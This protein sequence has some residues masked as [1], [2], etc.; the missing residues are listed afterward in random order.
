MADIIL[1]KP[2]QGQREVV[3][4]ATDSRIVLNFPADQATMEKSGQNLVFR[5]EDGGSVE[6]ENFYQQVSGDSIPEFQVDG[7]LVA[8]ADF[9]NAFGPDIAPAAGVGAGAQAGGRYRDYANMNLAEGVDHLRELDWGMQTGVEYNDTI[10]AAGAPDLPTGIRLN[11]VNSWVGGSNTG[12]EDKDGNSLASVND[13]V[14]TLNE[15]GLTGGTHEIDGKVSASSMLHVTTENSNFTGM[16][17]NGKYYSLNELSKGVE[18]G[19]DLD[20]D[21]VPDVTIKFEYAG[22]SNIKVSV[23]LDHNIRHLDD[24][25]N[26]LDE[27][28]GG[29]G[30]VAHDDKGN[31]ASG[32]LGVVVV[33]DNP[34]AYDDYQRMQVE[35]AD[36]HNVPTEITGN[37]VTGEGNQG[38][39]GTGKDV[40]GA[41]GLADHPV[42]WRPGQAST[43]NHDANP[44]AD[45]NFKTEFRLEGDGPT[46]TVMDG[47]K[48]VGELTL[49]DDGSYVFKVNPGYE[50]EHGDHT[51][52]IPYTVTDADGDSADASLHITIDNVNDR[53]VI[54]TPDGQYAG[55]GD[56]KETG[57]WGKDGGD[58]DG[59]LHDGTRGRDDENASTVDGGVDPGQH[60]PGAS[61]QLTATD[62]DGDRL[63]FGP[64]QPNAGQNVTGNADGSHTIHDQYGD[65]TIW[66]DG[67]WEFKLNE[68]AANHLGEGDKITVEFPV[69]VT[70]NSGAANN[71]GAGNIAINVHGSNDAPSIT[72]LPSLSI[73][74]GV[75]TTVNTSVSGKAEAT[76]PD[77]GAQLTFGLESPDGKVVNALYVVPDGSGGYMLSE[78][79]PADGN[80]YGRFTIGPDGNYTFTVNNGASCVQGMQ[81]DEHFDFNVS[82]V[83]QDEHGAYDK[84]NVGVTIN[85]HNDSPSITGGNKGAVKEDG[86]WGEKGGERDGY[87]HDGAHGRDD[88]NAAVKD[89][90][91]GKGEHQNEFEGKLTASDPDDDAS[92]LTFGP[93]DPNAS[94]VTD[95]GDGSYTIHGKYGDLTIN[96]DGSYKYTLDE[97]KAQELAE[98][99]KVTEDFPVT[100]KDPHGAAGDGKI[101]I[102]VHGTNDAPV[103]TEG[104][105]TFTL[106]E[107]G[108]DYVLNGKVAA[109]D[110]DAKE[111]GNLHFGFEAPDGSVQSVLYAVPD[112]QGGIT[113]VT[114]PPAD[115]NYYGRFTM[116]PDGSYKF[117]MNNNAQCVQELG[118]GESARISV[119]V[120]VRDPHGAYDKEDLN[121]TI[122]GSN[123]KAS[124]DVDALNP[125]QTVIEAGVKPG[126]NIDYAGKPTASG[127]IHATDPD[128]NDEIH[129]KVQDSDG[130]WIELGDTSDPHYTTDTDGNGTPGWVFDTEHGT[131]VITDNGDGSYH[132]E[133]TL[134]NDDPA[135]N[136]L[137]RQET[138]Q[139]GFP[140][141]VENQ[142][143]DS[144]DANVKITIVGTNDRPEIVDNVITVDKNAAD[145]ALDGS[146]AGRVSVSDVDHGHHGNT[147]EALADGSYNL[148][149]TGAGGKNFVDVYD[150]NGNIVGYAEINPDGSY[151]IT[152]NDLGRSLLQ[153]KAEGEHLEVHTPIRVTD[154]DGAYSETDVTWRLEG[155]DDAPRF[156]N[157]GIGMK[158]DGWNSGRP[159]IVGPDGKLA[160]N[161]AYSKD[162]HSDSISGKLGASVVDKTDQGAG[163]FTYGLDA[164]R[165]GTPDMN[166][167]VDT[168]GDGVNDAQH[169]YVLPDGSLSFGKPG[170]DYIGE[171]TLKPDGSWQF[172]LNQD[173][174]TVNKLRPGESLNVNIPV[175]V[176]DGREDPGNP[177]HGYTTGGSI[178][179]NVNG[180]NDR[181][182]IEK[183]PDLALNQNPNDPHAMDS[184]VV[185]GRAEAS[186]PDNVVY[187][188]DGSANLGGGTSSA[189]ASE[190]TFCFIDPVTGQPTQTLQLE[191][192]S[193]SIDAK[194]G[195][196]TYTY[197]VF[198]DSNY[199]PP[200]GNGTASYPAEDH[201]TIYARDKDGAYSN[202]QDVDVKIDSHDKWGQG[203]GPGGGQ[204]PNL[205]A[206]QNDSS[207][208]EDNHDHG[209]KGDA[210]VSVGG[211]VSGD[212][213]YFFVDGNGKHVQSVPAY[214]TNGNR[215]GSYVIDPVTGEYRFILDNGSDRIQELNE[216]E[217][218]TLAPP[219]VGSFNGG[220]V[221]LPPLNVVGTEDK[222]EFVNDHLWHSI[223]EDAAQNG[224]Y[225][226]SGKLEAHD[227]DKGD[228]AILQYAPGALRP[229]QTVDDNG[230]GT[231][232][233][234]GKYG[235]LV[236]NDKTGGY[237][238]TVR[239]GVNVPHG[240][241]G[242]DFDVKVTDDFGLSDNATIHIDVNGLNT[243]PEYKGPAPDTIDLKEDTG[244]GN[245][246]YITGGGQINLSDFVDADGDT[247]RLSV[248]PDKDG[249]GHADRGGQA[250]A[251]GEYGTLFIKSDGSYEYRLNNNMGAVQGLKDG[252]FLE[253]HFVVIADDGY[254]G[255]VEIPINVKV[256]GTNDN[257]VLSLNDLTG[258]QYGAGVSLNMVE[259]QVSVGGKAVATDVDKSDTDFE[260]S[261]KDGA[262]GAD[263]MWHLDA[264]ADIDAD[265]D[266]Q[267]DHI[268]VGEFVLDPATGEYKFIPNDN[269][270]HLKGGEQI[271]VKAEVVVESSDGHGHSGGTDS[272]TVTVNITGT[273]DAPIMQ[274][275]VIE[276]TEDSGNYVASGNLASIT[277]DPDAAPGEQG[278][279]FTVQAGNGVVQTGPN[280]WEGKYGTLTLNTDGTYTY[281]MHNDKAQS[282]AEGE[283]AQDEFTVI[284]KDQYGAASSSTITA[285]IEGTNDAPVLFNI[286]AANV[287]EGASVSGRFHAVDVDHGAELTFSVKDAVEDDSRDGFD[288]KVTGDY[289]DLYYNSKTGAYEYVAN[290]AESLSGGERVKEHFDVKVTDEHGA[291]DSKG[292][293]VNLTGTNQAPVLDPVASGS[294][295]EGGAYVTGT[296]HATD[297]DAKDVLTY[298]VDGAANDNSHAGYDKVVHGR[299]GD[300]YYN[301]KTGAYQYEAGH[302]LA[303][304]QQGQEDF[305]VRVND[306]HGG[307]DSQGL[308]VDVTGTNDAPTLS[309]MTLPVTE[310]ATVGGVFAGHD[311]DDGAV[312]TYSIGKSVND[313]S[314]AGYDKVV[315]GKYGDLFYNSKT[316][317]YEYV[318]DKADSLAEG[319]F[320]QESFTV[321]VKDEYGASANN[322]LTVNIAGAND[323]PTLAAATS[324]V[325]EDGAVRGAF[326]GH[327]VDSGAV[328]TYSVTGA[329]DDA[330]RGGFDHKIEGKYG[331]L[332][333]NSKTGAYEY[334]ANHADSLSQD[335]LVQES[336]PITVTDEHGASANNSLTVDITGANDA[337]SVSAANVTL[338][339]DTSHSAS[340]NGIIVFTDADINDELT[341]SVNGQVVNA[342]GFV[343]HGQYG[344]L[345]V[346]QDGTY[347]YEVKDMDALADAGQDGLKES[348]TA[349]VNDGHGMVDSTASFEITITHNSVGVVGDSIVGTANGDV[350][351]ADATHDI[352]G[353]AGDDVFVFTAGSGQVDVNGGDGL[354]VMLVAS[355]FEGD[356][357]MLLSQ[358][359][360]VEIVVKGVDPVVANDLSSIGITLENGG[361]KLDA[362]WT[363]GQPPADANG[364][365]TFTNGAGA[366]LMVVA[367]VQVSQEDQDVQQAQSAITTG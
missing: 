302:G 130:N 129:Y 236:V 36:G 94:N 361:I 294:T 26:A 155:Q 127:D 44:D 354:D 214:D 196:Y 57:V 102:D 322:S 84:G 187:R 338:D 91:V 22:N 49:N 348:F 71:T 61:G 69:S 24:L 104:P 295:T 264:Y 139:D 173:S 276:M 132:Y 226:T 14:F 330:S 231:H 244:F 186:D 180:T 339:T 211:K 81:D 310:N 198:D 358:A 342:D 30:L 90:G 77:D 222:P 99:Q 243:A 297:V 301:S 185:S 27:A 325:V 233:I 223:T 156:G 289:G 152:L 110:P 288:H 174:D 85:G 122:N 154:P 202:P 76:D 188:P 269:L 356:M 52:N 230:D 362:G 270:S 305:T 98:G 103:F 309:A 257:P 320:A 159:V 245:D 144:V 50:P 363:A 7:Q 254:G 333:Y 323:A 281:T 125:S 209:G 232:T 117:E 86:V 168:D 229:G 163:D 275:V 314:H 206:N 64:G 162:D 166:L 345:T 189:A 284:V 70:D 145:N 249:D 83:V 178:N 272:A 79:A 191:H 75:N 33:D 237:T 51:I 318:A 181:P 121:V 169:M 212:T 367:S 190:I 340:V 141:R 60:K 170:G 213:G 143:G 183:A 78:T 142:D 47:D 327:D 2:V 4:S 241:H 324:A 124:I 147:D 266:G 151:K 54:V 262:R 133:Y 193:V 311:V 219:T 286:T 296:F 263:G 42:A 25:G 116:N 366:T 114:T 247:V 261:L 248:A 217:T 150:G 292:L 256:E 216:G 298:S 101:S 313:S 92:S 287:L 274:P 227:L 321:R 268:K 201:F 12:T 334:V 300:L 177:G 341:L 148:V 290:N 38:G 319:Q 258:Q 253:D 17:I 293:D 106:V 35:D 6:L 259:G 73:E 255:K 135:V 280:T 308:H 197:N 9:F 204:G 93:K 13:G 53:P 265:G 349:G 260:F 277:V 10:L 282:L 218:I 328:L 175:A 136:S 267:P 37:V 210:S 199:A 115:G 221:Q 164:D 45:Q 18:I 96:P 123:D 350:L 56:V 138:T 109:T 220:Q 336:F 134:N 34:E 1:S 105:G 19:L 165:N 161:P 271:S 88:E 59:Y 315:H 365:Q 58:R 3:Q 74:E 184:Y 307:S 291:S 8:G 65:L 153:E 347:T 203:S 46:Y 332:Y 239:P 67:H 107:D 238:Y 146:F 335:Q 304:D 352:Y 82:V 207:V 195:E 357:D 215:V 68:D 43:D 41:D 40:A 149:V 179:I 100:V 200:N 108:G 140:V 48:V 303:K 95:N 15:S 273:N 63:A 160:P 128:R 112:G 21:G 167:N 23:D 172:D 87:L 344:D 5:F 126:G 285:D 20:G 194:T 326:V 359:K 346:N 343:V 158:E 250:Y 351:V 299:H 355:D 312:L 32:S 225:G 111:S 235:D 16:T 62:A 279:S 205:S 337:P 28:L 252:E 306:G 39:P 317:A 364:T 11:W 89:G 283:H 171:I 176:E 29:L 329:V 316:G 192:G 278:P 72:V 208:W 353:G 97:G 182:S 240:A 157:V 251:V 228:D 120:V 119:P 242:E 137:D 31:S 331:D 118:D 246:G 113:F 234:H 224:G 360:D 55:A 66:P 80:Y 131:V